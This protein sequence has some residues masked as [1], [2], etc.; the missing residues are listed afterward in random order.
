[1][2]IRTIC[3][4]SSRRKA[5]LV[6]TW[7]L[8]IDDERDLSYIGVLDTVLWEVARS[9]EQA[10]VLVEYLGPPSYISFDHDL[11]GEDTAMV[12]L[13][14]LADN[15]FTQPPEY[16]IHSSNPVGRSNIDAYMKSWIRVRNQEKSP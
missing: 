5:C 13:K 15:Y 16:S 12:F 2:G 10:K 14:W 8:F 6:M 11:G 3:L 4:C 9:T 7:K 1:M